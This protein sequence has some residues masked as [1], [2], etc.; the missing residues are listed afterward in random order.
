MFL[1]STSCLQ[2]SDGELK[3]QLQ[4]SNLEDTPQVQDPPLMVALLCGG[5]LSGQ[6][7]SLTSAQMLMQQLQTH[8]SREGFQ[9]DPAAPSA[10][11]SSPTDPDGP[12]S[13]SLGN[14][15]SDISRTHSSTFPPM[16]P[17]AKRTDLTGIHFVPIFITPDHHAMP[18]TAAELCGKNAATLQFEAGLRHRQIV[19]LAQLGQQLQ[20]IADVALST[21]QH[22]GAGPVQSALQTAG[23]PIVGPSSETFH[24]TADKF[25]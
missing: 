4:F 1:C 14:G 20:G 9:G 25:R 6:H 22:S 18:I 21:L 7:Q 2:V 12:S 10:S 8:N 3:E 15:D 19:S 5:P 13:S 16:L 23:L 17:T 24:M 11:P